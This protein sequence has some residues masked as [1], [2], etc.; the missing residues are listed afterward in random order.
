MPVVEFLLHFYHLRPHVVDLVGES[1][2][3]CFFA[4][5]FFLEVAD[6]ALE[7]EYFSPH[8]VDL[9]SFL[10]VFLDL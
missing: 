10:V 5:D 9:L 7:A 2:V 4:E 8:A 3:C 6:V 1:G